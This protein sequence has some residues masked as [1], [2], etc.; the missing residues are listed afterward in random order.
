MRRVLEDI[1]ATTP[2][3][4]TMSL[5]YDG[6]WPRSITCWGFIDNRGRGVTVCPGDGEE[7]LTVVL[8][9]EMSEEVSESSR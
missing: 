5:E 2:F 7:H 3:R 1:D 6:D 8:A 9:D 4:R